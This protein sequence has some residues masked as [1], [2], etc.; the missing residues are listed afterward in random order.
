VLHLYYIKEMLRS[1][2]V[3]L[4]LVRI[5]LIDEID[6][7]EEEKAK[8]HTT[9]I[10]YLRINVKINPFQFHFLMTTQCQIQLKKIGHIKY[11]YLL[12]IDR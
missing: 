4:T 6:R 1:Y 9:L 10:K 5:I 8:V 7:R 11:S 3:R 12:I 2:I